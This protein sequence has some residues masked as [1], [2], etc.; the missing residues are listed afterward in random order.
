MNRKYL[1]WIGKDRPTADSITSDELDDLL[2]RL[3]QEEIFSCA[4]LSRFFPMSD[5]N[6]EALT[7]DMFNAFR[8]VA[9]RRYCGSTSWDPKRCPR[10]VMKAHHFL[11]VWETT[12][13]GGKDPVVEKRLEEIQLSVTRAPMMCWSD[14]DAALQARK[15]VPWLLARVRL[16]Q[17]TVRRLEGSLN[18]DNKAES[19]Q[20]RS[21]WDLKAE[22]GRLRAQVEALKAAAEASKGE[23]WSAPST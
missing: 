23:P 7:A 22:N 10:C 20:S 16:L 15:D 19:R 3:E 11:T 9:H 1:P 8:K 17:R 6:Y 13:Q 14:T 21:A 2:H 5:A 4:L 12:Q 18:K